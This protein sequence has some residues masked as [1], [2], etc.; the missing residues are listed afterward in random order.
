[1]AVPKKRKT[2]SA[3][4]ARRSHKKLTALNLVKCSNCNHMRR[5]HTVCTS[6]GFYKGRKVA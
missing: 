5:P 4:D 3:I 1:M 6:C 2:K